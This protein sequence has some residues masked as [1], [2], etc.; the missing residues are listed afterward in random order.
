MFFSLFVFRPVTSTLNESEIN[1]RM[2]KAP[3]LSVKSTFVGSGI[4]GDSARNS[5]IDF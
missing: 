3:L 2:V 5:M 4:G 1:S